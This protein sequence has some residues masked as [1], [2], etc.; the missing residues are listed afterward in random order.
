M[1]E[2]EKI[3]HD[4]EAGHAPAGADGEAYVRVFKAL[5][6]EPR[7]V[8]PSSFAD[9]VVQRAMAMDQA[10][11]SSRDMWWLGLGIAL[12][13][14]AFIIAFAFVGF[15]MNLGYLKVF[16]DFKWLLLSGA[17]LLAVFNIIDKKLVRPPDVQI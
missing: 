17:V 16:N 12:I 10:R 3:Q 9:K 4:V 11:E 15:R 6:R 8:L 2:D 1:S 13:T 7:F 5:S 14:V